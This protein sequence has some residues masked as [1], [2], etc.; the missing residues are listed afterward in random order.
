MFFLYSPEFE[1]LHPHFSGV[2]TRLRENS[3]LA[4]AHEHIF[5]TLLG[6]FGLKTPYHDASL[7]LTTPDVQP[8]SGMQPPVHEN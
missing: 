6:I 8:Y 4:V 3:R 2:L 7:D 1:R 5:H